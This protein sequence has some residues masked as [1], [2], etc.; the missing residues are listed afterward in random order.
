MQRCQ[1][2]DYSFTVLTSAYNAAGTMHRPYESLLEQTFGD[3]EWIIVDMGSDETNLLVSEWLNRES[4]FPIRYFRMPNS[5]KHGAINF[6]VEKACGKLFVVLDAD[7]ECVPEALERMNYHWDSIP[8]EYKEHFAGVGVLCRNQNGSLVG[9]RFPSDVT[10]AD[11]LGLWHR[12][13]VRGEKW[14][15]IRTEVMRE[16]PFPEIPEFRSIPE[17]TIL[18]RMARKYQIRWINEILRVYW[19]HPQ[20]ISRRLDPSVIAGPVSLLHSVRL[21]EQ[22]DWFFC[23]PIFYS[24]SAIHYSRFCF[25]R[26]LGLL[27]QV[28]D[29]K[30]IWARLLWG[31]LLPVG[32]LA[33]LKDKH[34]LNA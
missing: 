11:F 5:G 20:S 30:N 8:E 15:A 1:Q 33:Y 25:H 9:S 28:K 14:L 24:K 18:F 7:D 22:L 16:F 12:F 17:S 3:F 31:I 29:L 34:T 23:S 26:G 19:V 32:Y 6:G 21:N 27:A 13:K 2:N 10:D 4:P